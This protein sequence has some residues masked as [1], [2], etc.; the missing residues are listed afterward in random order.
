VPA[1]LSSK[2]LMLEITLKILFYLVLSNY[3]RASFGDPGYVDKMKLV[4]ESGY[5]LIS[6][7]NLKI[8]FQKNC[9]KCAIN[10]MEYGSLQGPII[11]K[12]VKDVY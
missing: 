3:L 10:A 4:N 6:R 1:D 9:I 2:G 7:A 5:C 12:Y 11:A 8:S